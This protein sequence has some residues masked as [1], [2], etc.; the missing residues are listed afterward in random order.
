MKKQSLGLIVLFLSMMTFTSKSQDT[1][2]LFNQTKLICKVHKISETEIEYKKWENLDGPIYTIDKVKVYEIVFKNGM[3]EKV[4]LDEMDVYKEHEIL[5]KTNAVKLDLFSPVFDKITLG[6]EHSMKIG[7]NLEGYAS[8]ISNNIL[9]ASFSDGM[10]QNKKVQGAGIKLCNKF[11]LGSD[12]Y[13]KGTKYAH[14]L[15]GRFIRIDLG[16]DQFAIKDLYRYTYTGYQ[17]IIDRGNLN[18]SQYNVSLTYGRQL[19]LSN[20]ISIQ[21]NIGLGYTGTVD[22]FVV[23]ETNATPSGPYYGYY[24]EDYYNNFYGSI[25]NIIQFEK[26]PIGVSGNLTVGYIF[27]MKNKHKKEATDKK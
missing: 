2:K 17:N 6:F 14:P 19:I 12:Y 15:K 13:I 1:L 26:I 11:F 23:T 9:P 24:S 27:G 22:N 8:F 3:V 16:F 21:Y 10:F 20:V 5:S 7:W 25:G 18:V 4:V